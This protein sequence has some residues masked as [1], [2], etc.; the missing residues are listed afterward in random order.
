MLA[1]SFKAGELPSCWQ[2]IRTHSLVSGSHDV[3][4]SMFGARV[5]LRGMG[6]GHTRY[7]RHGE[8]MSKT[9]TRT[10]HARRASVVLQDWRSVGDSDG[11]GRPRYVFV[12][13]CDRDCC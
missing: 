11:Q 8:S 4:N 7:R 10:P 1:F 5:R 12:S 6:I 3:V 9:E 2:H 13:D